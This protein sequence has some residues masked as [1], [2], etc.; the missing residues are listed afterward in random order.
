MIYA[1][2]VAKKIFAETGKN[3]HRFLYCIQTHLFQ[4]LSAEIINVY[5]DFKS[6]WVFF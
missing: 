5:I 2:H 1:L 6:M 3:H 4:I